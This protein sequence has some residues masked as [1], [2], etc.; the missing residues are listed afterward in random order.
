MEVQVESVVVDPHRSR[1][2]AGN[3]EQLVAESWCQPE[4]SLDDPF[5]VVIG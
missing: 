1:D 2:V 4:P 3:G 5:H